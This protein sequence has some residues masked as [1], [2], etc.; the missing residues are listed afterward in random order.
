MK[1]KSLVM[2]T[3]VALA[4]VLGLAGGAWAANPDN[5]TITNISAEIDTT[6]PAFGHLSHHGSY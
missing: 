2:A 4:M 5:I 3:C 1:N 6:S